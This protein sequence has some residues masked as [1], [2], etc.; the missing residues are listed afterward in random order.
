[1]KKTLATLLVLCLTL[2]GCSM[3]S[4]AHAESAD[5]PTTFAAGDYLYI[6]DSN[7]NATITNWSGPD[8]TLKIQEQLDGHPVTAIGDYAFS[9]C[10]SLATVTIPDS[11]MS[12]GANLFVNYSQLS[13]SV[14]SN[15]PTL[16]TIDG[17]LFNKPRKTLICYPEGFTATSYTIPNGIVTIG[18]DA[19]DNCDS[20]TLTVNSS[21]YAA[22]YAEKNSL[23]YIY[24]DA[25]DWLNN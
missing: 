8:T 2:F 4:A 9:S 25:C 20:L 18:D 5:T 17:V 23:S 13:T 10:E 7:G 15:H 16:A 6:L 1:M 14:S 11:V 24:P 21:S 12:I 22:Q 3:A 19:F